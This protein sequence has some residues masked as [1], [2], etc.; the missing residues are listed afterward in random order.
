MEEGRERLNRLITD[1]RQA[2]AELAF[3][4]GRYGEAARLVEAILERDPF[5]EGAH[6][7]GMRIANATGD[8]DR[9]IAA[10]RCCEEALSR[11]G[12]APSA[13][14]RRLETLKR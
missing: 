4:T 1:A 10:Y 13:T 2:A 12:T 8:E 5:R 14:T 6:R 9:V 11:L 7:L 3:S